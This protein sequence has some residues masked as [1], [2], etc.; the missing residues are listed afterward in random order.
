MKNRF[1]FILGLLIIFVYTGTIIFHQLKPLPEGFSYAGDFHPLADG[2]I[3]FIYDLT[4]QLDGEEHYEHHIY[5]NIVEV[6][7]EAEHFLIIDMFMFNEMSDEERDF[8][9]TS[10]HL[11]ETIAKKMEAQPD[12]KVIIITDHINTT[13]RS[14]D[15]QHI[16]PL[17]EL[18][19]EVIYTD[20][21]RLRDP[22]PLYSG[23]WR[24]FFQWFGQKGTGWLPNPFGE[25]S[26]DVTFRSYLKLANVKANHRKA[27]I[28]ENAGLYMSWNAHDAS[29]LHSDIAVRAEGMIIKDMVEAEK[30]VAAFSGNDLSSFPT[31]AELT[32]LL[33]SREEAPSSGESSIVA[34][35]VTERQIE[36]A[37]IEGLENAEAG[38]MVWI[39]MFYLSD[40]DIIEAIN[41]AASRGV[42]FRLILDPNKNAFGQ[43]KIGLPNIPVAE[44]LLTREDDNIEIRWY[45]TNEEQYHTKMA[46]IIRNDE[47]QVIAGSTNFTTRNLNNYNPENNLNIIADPD[48]EFMQSIDSYFHRLWENEDADFTVPYEEYADSLST[49]RYVLYVLQKIFRV[50]TY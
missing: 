18:G 30:A 5:E 29:S 3:E 43:E 12:L 48:T 47:S 39:G 33:D 50:T 36:Y 31:E 15:A 13:Y 9:P 11:S 17:E 41:N 19:A 28:S 16:D 49:A 40:R 32:E 7:E 35:V 1:T 4:Y 34:Q 14:H 46:Y 22:T 42:E 23:A 6:I 20:L 45:N 10:A 38:D 44:E 21:T 24:M 27:V 25:N 37:F 26:P 8:P 2:E